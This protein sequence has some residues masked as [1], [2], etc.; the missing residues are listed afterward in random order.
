MARFNPTRFPPGFF[1]LPADA[2]RDLPLDIIAAWARSE[3]T[4]EAASELLAPC[5][6]KGIVVSSDSA[7]LTRLTQERSLIEILAMVSR[8]K[9]L[10]HAYGRG[11][12]GIPLGVWAAD[13]TLMFYPDG[14]SPDHVVSMLLALVDRVRSDCEVGIGLCAHRGTFYELGKGIYGPDADRVQAVAE[15][16]TSAGELLLT[17]E[18][19]AALSSAASFRLAPREDLRAAFGTL[20]RVEDGARLGGIEASDFRYPLPF[21]DEFY[22]GLVE[23]QRTRRTSVV[24]RP[25][26]RDAVVLVVE[27]EREDQD[28]PEVAALNDL[29]LSA[30]VKRLGQQLTGE[31]DGL[32]VKTSNG[33]SIYLFDDAR[34]GAE[35]ARRLRETLA[36]EGVQLR[37]GIDVGRVLVFELGLGLKD[38]AGSPVN[39][40]SKLAQDVGRYGAIQL[41]REAA[42]LAGIEG[43]PASTVRVSGVTIETVIL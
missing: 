41:T 37:I 38:I 43:A 7:G 22:G 32:E 29:A 26:Y 28:V 25:A 2:G 11:I 12:G 24:P 36:A 6:L 40:A 20:Y 27:R 1:D 39:V 16:Y 8:P 35:F 17:G 31:L 18:L 10:V 9:E 14:V 21:S 13:N 5:T 3:Q 15:D 4:W 19:V 34:R 30:A 33:V 42:R 23:F